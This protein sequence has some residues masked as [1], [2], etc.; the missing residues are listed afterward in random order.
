MRRQEIQSDKDINE[1]LDMGLGASDLAGAYYLGKT[2]NFP[3]KIELNSKII[4]KEILKNSYVLKENIY[5]RG[6]NKYTEGR[7]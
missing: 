2:Q 6:F 1:L 5:Y 7:D 3:V 4:N